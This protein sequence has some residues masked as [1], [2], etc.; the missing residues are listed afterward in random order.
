MSY[1]AD[2]PVDAY[3]AALPAWQQEICQR[4]RELVHAADPEVTETIKRTV[5]PYFVLDGNVCALLA[6]KN[7][8]NVFLYD[9]G[10]VP[11]PEGI[12]TDGHDNKTARRVAFRAGEPI[13]EPALLA[14][15]RQIIADNRAGGW[16]TL[17]ARGE[18]SG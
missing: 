6:A 12:I 13:N 16:R 5:Q 1:V 8:V 7:H 17:R 11:D 9:G 3:L 18:T 10:I 15:F 4:V 2:P 14:M